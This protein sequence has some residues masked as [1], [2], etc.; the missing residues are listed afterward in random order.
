MIEVEE[1]SYAYR[2]GERRVPA[3]EDL[4][5]SVREGEFVAVIGPNGSGKTTLGEQING[6]LL[7]DKGRVRV[8]GLDTREDPWGVRERVGMV[9]QNPDHQ[10]F[11]ATVEEDIAFGPENLGLPEAEVEARVEAG[12]DA[13]GITPLRKLPPYRL[14]GGEK[15]L[16]AIA[17]VLAME[18]KYLVL[19]EPTSLLDP[20]GRRR[21]FSTVRG[22]KDGRRGILYITHDMAE[23]ARA[24][25][26]YVLTE[27]KV[28]LSGPPHEVFGK[29]EVL[30]GVGLDVPPVVELLHHLQ[31][32]GY[33]VRTDLFE[34]EEALMEILREVGGGR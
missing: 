32:K 14:S 29:M 4:S 28:L 5:L 25:R 33:P 31:E 7:P 9:F 22:L 13:V 1:I 24:E 11:S 20:Q 16:V 30:R 18:P 8:D 10:I 19:D 34:A 23:A 17:G 21:V 2:L 6:L 12:L 27:G 15:Q 3:L 26:V